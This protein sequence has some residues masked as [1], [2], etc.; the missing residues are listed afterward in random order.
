MKKDYKGVYFC[1]NRSAKDRWKA[2]IVI[3]GN[4][5]L[6]GYYIDER[7]AAIEYDKVAIKHGLPTNILKSAN[8]I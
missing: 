3:A 5:H 7:T 6:V 1:P 8:K 4:R 2:V